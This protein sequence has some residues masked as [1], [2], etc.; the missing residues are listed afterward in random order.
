MTTPN[1][2]VPTSPVSETLPMTDSSSVTDFQP[3]ALDSLAANA[4]GAAASDMIVGPSDYA[5]TP[6]ARMSRCNVGRTEQ[7]FR[8]GAGAALLSAAAFAPISLGWRIGLGMLG[9][10]ELIT[11]ITRYCPLSEALGINTCRGDER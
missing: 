11:G 10:G 9:A 5:G 6:L 3:D 1:L 7:K 2:D 4:F 8:I